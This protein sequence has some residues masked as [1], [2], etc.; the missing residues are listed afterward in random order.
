MAIAI[1]AYSARRRDEIGALIVGIQREEFGPDILLQDQPDLLDITSFYQRGN[2]GFWVAVDNEAV[3]G[4]I[5][6]QTSVAAMW[7]CARCS[8]RRLGCRQATACVRVGLRKR[9][10]RPQR[11]PRHHR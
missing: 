7:R 5:G 8:W 9:S 2:G 11:I 4:T 10:W 6:W 3:V 1:V